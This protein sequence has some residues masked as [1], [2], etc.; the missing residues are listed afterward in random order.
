MWISV[1]KGI[2]IGSR[3][4][5]SM[6]SF[7]VYCMPSSAS[8]ERP[9][10]RRVLIACGVHSRTAARGGG[11]ERRSGLSSNRCFF[12][13]GLV[14]SATGDTSLRRACLDTFFFRSSFGNRCFSWIREE[15]R[16][17][18]LDSCSSLPAPVLAPPVDGAPPA[19]P[20]FRSSNFATICESPNRSVSA[21]GLRAVVGRRW[22]MSRPRGAAFA[23]PQRT[24]VGA[25][26][27][28][29]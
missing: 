1:D 14:S 4:K 18:L 24:D 2:L 27:E 11:G 19:T 8:A 22:D 6:Q 23:W 15:L 25:L 7:G 29:I 5:R 17:C 28:S 12:C 21:H 16:V 26:P 3:A 13:G 10:L 20:S 9:G